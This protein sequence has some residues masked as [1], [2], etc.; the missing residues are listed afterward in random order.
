MG[1]QDIRRRENSSSS[2]TSCKTVLSNGEIMLKLDHLPLQQSYG[3][4]ASINGVSEPCLGLIRER[5][6]GVLSLLFRH[7]DQDLAD[8][9]GSKN[10]VHLG[11]LLALIR[12]KVRCK[13]T[14]GQRERERER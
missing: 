8:I 11:K 9:A 3:T 5:I 4:N 13:N 2:V 6:D 10:L 7:F 14:I 12:P 1:M